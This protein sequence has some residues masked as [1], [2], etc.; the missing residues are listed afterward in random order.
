VARSSGVGAKTI[1]LVTED[2]SVVAEAQSGRYDG[3][4]TFV[5]TSHRRRRTSSSG[6]SSG[7]NDGGGGQRANIEHANIEHANIGEAILAGEID[8]EGEALNA[9][10]NLLLS[11]ECDLLVGPLSST[12]TRMTLL[13][14]L[15]KYNRP[16]PYK[17]VEIPSKKSWQ[18]GFGA[19][20]W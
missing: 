5:F 13:L 8:G 6:E 9:L 16:M 7:R 20:T 3:E 10:A 4:F 19:C 15:G 18:W 2:P 17:S 14:A 11:I 1:L 12:W